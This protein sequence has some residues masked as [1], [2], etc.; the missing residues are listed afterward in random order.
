MRHGYSAR[1]RRGGRED[2]TRRGGGLGTDHWGKVFGLMSLIR[3]GVHRSGEHSAALHSAFCICLDEFSGIFPCDRS[4]LPCRRGNRKSRLLGILFRAA[5]HWYGRERPC[6]RESAGIDLEN[7]ADG[8]ALFLRPHA[9]WLVARLRLSAGYA[10]AEP[11]LC[12]QYPFT[13][14]W[15][16]GGVVPSLRG[17]SLLP[18]AGGS[19]GKPCGTRPS[20]PGAG[21][22]LSER[23]FERYFC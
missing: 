19:I 13:A 10:R 15:L 12:S 21:F 3:Q 9:N 11:S 4:R 18:P 6:R 7:S 5:W 20:S 23:L 2:A 14:F 8:L 22:R 17:L 16:P 1:G